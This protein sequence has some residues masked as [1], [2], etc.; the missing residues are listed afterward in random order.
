MQFK[1]NCA[2]CM[3]QKS[4]QTQIAANCWNAVKK[5]IKTSSTIKYSLDEQIRDNPEEYCCN[6]LG[7]FGKSSGFTVHIFSDFLR[8]F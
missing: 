2:V 1:F 6:Y 5:H 3:T 7:E 8:F 4:D